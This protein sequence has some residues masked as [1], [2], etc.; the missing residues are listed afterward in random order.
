MISDVLAGNHGFHQT[1]GIFLLLLF[2]HC[3]DKPV[4]ISHAL[5]DRCCEGEIVNLHRSGIPHTQKER[6]GLA[7]GSTVS[8]SVDG[9]ELCGQ[10]DIRLRLHTSASGLCQLPAAESSCPAP[11]LRCG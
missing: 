4:D 1:M 3:L 8:V 9:A 6:G 10:L 5:C 7:A 11:A 2:L